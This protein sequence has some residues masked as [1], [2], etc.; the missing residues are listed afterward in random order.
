MN[1]VA[2]TSEI[3]GTTSGLPVQTLTFEGSFVD[4]GTLDIH[5]V[6]NTGDDR[7]HSGNNNDDD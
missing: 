3:S 7:R 2:P 5:I 6:L 4:P 1:N